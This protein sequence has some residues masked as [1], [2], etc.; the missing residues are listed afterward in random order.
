MRMGASLDELPRLI[1]GEA[2]SPGVG[3]PWASEAGQSPASEARHTPLNGAGQTPFNGA[4][5][6]PMS[7]AVNGAGQPLASEARQTPPMGEAG[8]PLASEARRPA[9]SVDDRALMEA[10]G[11]AH[12]LLMTHPIA[13]QSLFRAFVAEGRRF[14]LTEE[15]AALRAELADSELIRQGRVVWEGNSFNM[16]EEQS[17]SSTLLPTALLDALVAA[18]RHDDLDLLL[19]RFAN[20]WSRADDAPDDPTP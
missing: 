11:Q 10:F 1:F 8:E 3:E 7:E 4:R 17:P 12:R 9:V 6:S 13:A 14:A 20:P 5:Q 18:T 16:L 15:G 2:R 19:D